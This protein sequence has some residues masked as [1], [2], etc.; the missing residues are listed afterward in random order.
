MTCFPK[1]AGH[2]LQPGWRLCGKLVVA[3]IGT[4]ASVF[5]PMFE[6]G[7]PDTFANDPA[8]W[9][10]GRPA[11]QPDRNKYTRRHGLV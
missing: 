9:A 4:P 2:L 10:D 3:D 11:L 5:E 6:H 1:K 8:Q 7:V